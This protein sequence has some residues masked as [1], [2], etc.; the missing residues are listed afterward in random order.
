M[1]IPTAKLFCELHI[2]GRRP[3]V[4]VEANV[5]GQGGALAER[6]R[7]YAR[8][9]QFGSVDKYVWA[10]AVR[11]DEAEVAIIDPFLK[12][13]SL[14]DFL[15]RLIFEALHAGFAAALI[16]RAADHATHVPQGTARDCKGG[17][18]PD[19]DETER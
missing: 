2:D 16:V 12:F 9:A 4:A 19:T 1:R 5:E 17:H 10:A 13:S 11:L 7:I 6:I 8:A 18:S 14:H 15:I 3:V